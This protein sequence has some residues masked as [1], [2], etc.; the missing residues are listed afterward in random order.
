MLKHIYVINFIFEEFDKFK[1]SYIS[2]L[3]ILYCGFEIKNHAGFSLKL[4]LKW[5]IFHISYIYV[6]NRKTCMRQN[7]NY[8]IIRKNEK[9]LGAKKKKKCV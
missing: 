3:L 9:V 4:S 1:I 2:K 6:N 8:P 5:P 7:P